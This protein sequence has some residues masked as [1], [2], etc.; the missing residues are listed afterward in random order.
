MHSVQAPARERRPSAVARRRFGTSTAHD[1]TRRLPHH[2]P[3]PAGVNL[4]REKFVWALGP[5]T[6]PC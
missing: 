5:G 6:E 1:D 3:K 2:T 4:K